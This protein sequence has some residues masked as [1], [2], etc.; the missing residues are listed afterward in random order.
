[1]KRKI[2][3]IS[4]KEDPHTK[5]VKWGLKKMKADVTHWAW[6]EFPMNSSCCFEMGN[7]PL[8]DTF[9]LETQKIQKKN[10]FDV[11]WVRR[12][13][14]PSVKKGTHELDIEFV[15]NESKTFLATLLPHV[16][17]DDCI[18]INHPNSSELAKNKIRQLMI[19]R[20]LGF[21]IP[22]T[23]IGNSFSGL[24]EFNEKLRNDLILK[25]FEQKQWVVPN[26]SVVYTRTSKVEKSKLRESFPVEAC[27]NIY[28]EYIE[29]Q[30]EVRVTVIG[31]AVFASKINANTTDWRFDANHGNGCLSMIELPDEVA[32]KSLAICREFGLNFAAID[33]AVEPSGQYVFFELNHAGQFLWIDSYCS[34]SNLLREFCGFLAGVNSS[35]FQFNLREFADEL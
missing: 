4:S 24:T 14:T 12:F 30:F 27:P 23:F 20:K 10:L 34:E 31:N 29:K 28:Q 21:R 16:A 8:M 1:M 9:T 33:F 7:D 11:I 15:L 3:I 6:D 22:H 19:A 35:G 32:Q 13:A 5:L 25:S 18:W 2:L 26:D 17:S